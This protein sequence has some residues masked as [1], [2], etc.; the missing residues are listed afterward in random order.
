MADQRGPIVSPQMYRDYIKPRHRRFFDMIHAS[1]R[2]KLLFHSCG[3][4]Y[5]LLPDFVDIGVDLINPVQVSCSDMDTARLKREFGDDL[6]F[7]GAIDSQEVLPHGT[8]E[9]VRA[10][11][12]RRLHD[13]GPGGGYMLA[14]V[15]N[16][17]HDVPVENICA[18]YDAARATAP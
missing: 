8:P 15:H 9:Q 2:A 5:K 11:V 18:L 12:E 16:L 1:T 13:L 10:E 3:S 4:V 6:G 7:W 17:Q 14:A